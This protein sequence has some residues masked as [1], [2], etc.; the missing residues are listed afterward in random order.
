MLMTAVGTMCIM[1]A[2]DWVVS[3]D[4]AGGLPAVS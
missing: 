1:D 3:M 2:L 4:G